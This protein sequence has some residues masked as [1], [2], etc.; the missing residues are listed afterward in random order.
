LI[1]RSIGG[2]ET[3]KLKSED[4]VKLGKEKLDEIVDFTI[5]TFKSGMTA[6]EAVDHI[7][8]NDLF[9]LLY[10]DEKPIGFAGSKYL[11]S[12]GNIYI[13]AYL[14]AAVVS[15]EFQGLGLYSELVKSRIDEALALGLRMIMTRTQ[16]PL[17]EFTIKKD[18][19]ARVGR[20][21]IGGYSL[22]TSL[23]PGVFGRRLTEDFK[24][25]QDEAINEKYRQLDLGRGDGYYLTFSLT[26]DTGNYFLPV[27]GIW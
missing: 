22:T 14:S 25:C 16:N 24:G 3:F 6:A 4:P 26:L 2:N 23:L 10:K 8:G 9:L 18:L 20:G 27:K 21:E 15:T 5:K 12:K 1:G 7:K 13:Y 11:Y 19:D 17:V